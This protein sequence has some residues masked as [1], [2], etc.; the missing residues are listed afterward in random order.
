MGQQNCLISWLKILCYSV[1]GKNRLRFAFVL[2]NRPG[3]VKGCSYKHCSSL[4]NLLGHWVMVL[5]NQVTQPAQF[6]VAQ[7]NRKHILFHIFR[8]FQV[9]KYLKIALR[10]FRSY[11]NKS[12]WLQ[13]G[14]FCRGGSV[15][16]GRV[17]YQHGYPV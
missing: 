13:S 15:P 3:K 7:K 10:I 11:V 2:I 6:E 8:I 5:Q 16:P 14:G 9:W 1:E 12:I 17:C 4:N